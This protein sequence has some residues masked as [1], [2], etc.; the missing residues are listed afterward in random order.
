VAP[1]ARRC[2]SRAA[3]EPSVPPARNERAGL[4]LKLLGGFETRLATGPAV[5]LPTRKAQALL[6]YLAVRPGQAHARDKLAALLWADRGEAQARDSLRHTLMALRKVLPARPPSLV[7][8]GR[9]VA[10]DPAAVD[11]DVVRFV[12]L[13][14][15]GTAEGLAQAAEVYQGDFLEGFVLREPSFEEWLVAERERLRERA[16]DALRRLLDLQHAARAIE[17]AIRTAL[18]LLALDATQEAAH[19]ALMRLYVQQGRRAAALRQYQTCVGVLQ[20]E[21]GIEPEVATRQ[22]YQEIVQRRDEPARAHPAS[23]KSPAE[24]VG[25][26]RPGVRGES[27]AVETPLIGRDTELDTLRNAFAESQ[28][29][30]G[31]VIAIIGEAGVGKS[32]LVA[33]LA[34]TAAEQDARVLLGRCY[35]SE[36]MLPFGP[37]VDALRAGQVVPEDPA[38]LALEPAWLAELARLFPEIVAAGLPAPS[39]DARRLFESVVQ[40]V[41]SVAARQ[42]V[43]LVLEDVHW[44]DEMSLRLLSFLGRRVQAWPV[45][46]VATVREEELADA[47]ALRRALGELRGEDH[48]GELPLSPLSRPDTSSLVRFLTVAGSEPSTLAR[49][50]EQ[51]WAASEGNPFVIVETVRALREGMTL[52]E[53]ANLSLPQRVRDVIAGRLGRLSEGSRRLLSV[54]AVI[55]REFNFALLQ[56]ASGATDRD[57][58][59]SVEELVRRRMLHGVDEGFDFTHDRIREVVY[60]GLLPPRRKLL[61]GDV[62]AA[63]E[64]LSAGALDPP[65]AALGMHYRHAEVW[66]KA[67]FYLRQAGGKAAARSALPDARVWFEQ[68]L[69][70]LEALPESPSTLEQAFDIR[71]E[72][73]PVL[74]LLGEPRRTLERLRAAESLAEKLNDDRR[75]GW[76]GAFLAHIH[77]QLGELDEALVTGTRALEIAG[78]L[79]D[80]RLRIVTTIYLEQ[81]YYYRG[82]YERVVELATGNLAA[83]PADWVYEYFGMGALPS[84]W[85]RYWLVM[86][87]AE[88]GRF[89]EAGPYE[90]E[91]I[92]LA[93][94]TQRAFNVGV[95]YRAAGT[96]DLL[97]GDWAKARSS[98]EQAIAVFRAGSIVL[99]IPWAVASSAWV[100]AQ[101]GEGS[102][103]L[104]RLR[105]GEQLVERLA[106]RGIVHFASWDYHVLGRACLLLNRVDEARRLGDLAVE[107]SPGHRGFAAHALHLLG[108]IT[109]HPDRFDADRGE[110]HYRNSLALAEPRGMRP[111][112]AHCH[113]GLGKLYGRTGK[114][115]QTQE[116]LSVATTMYRELEM[117]FWLEQAEATLRQV[118]SPAET[119]G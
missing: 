36:Q 93:E 109:T 63:L 31:G 89:A 28:W 65:A 14:D 69:G 68:A 43:L 54:A 16:L 13:V 84:V 21:I 48:F 99:H 20:R 112:I 86:S 52:Q 2:Y 53:P 8:E 39:D 79:G 23:S 113:L 12:S 38:L 27:V 35:E 85:D 114:R 40:V 77:S 118:A 74:V 50:E 90:A 45:L 116:H 66:D 82:E 51:A 57:A 9:A 17:P 110:A 108:D 5:T 103:A 59:A 29:G 92:R 11:V 78:R 56:R 83:L 25:R 4:R 95:A 67:V 7:V 80:S 119:P 111:L 19:Q 3:H 37:W 1:L 91:A 64:A 100:L 34:R 101:L 87:L 94:P 70:A 33:E 22:L 46:A 44:A 107:F 88:L 115:E 102:E 76:V 71:L 10:L 96:L 81:T 62:A 73:R 18:R 104:N 49:L 72:L 117:P 42:P 47:D 60:G 15:A 26:P 106:A 58:A 32:R 97:R 105:E 41:R 75:R 61:H 6:A 30:R 98:I 55:G 24:P